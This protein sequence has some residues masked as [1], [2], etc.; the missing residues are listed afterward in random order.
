MSFYCKVC[1]E[2]IKLKKP[3]SFFDSR[4]SS[5]KY[6][7]F[8][9]QFAN[10]RFLLLP[11]GLFFLAAY[12]GIGLP[13]FFNDNDLWWLFVIMFPLIVFGLILSIAGLVSI[14]I[15][16][17]IKKKLKEKRFYCFYCGYDITFTSK[18]GSLLCNS[19]GN[20]VLFCNLCSKIV[21]PNEQ[22]AIIKPCNHIFHKNELLDF[23][24]EGNYCPK[25]RGEIKELSFKIDKN[26]EMFW[27][28][29]K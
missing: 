8:R 15:H 24:E 25:C 27:Q 2:R 26:D 21:N 19:C 12:I 5:T 14:I 29:T 9:C 4:F 7:S 10:L 16:S 3:K 20:K 13:L 18:E 1:E 28:K 11:L 17:R 6:C 22:I 23:V